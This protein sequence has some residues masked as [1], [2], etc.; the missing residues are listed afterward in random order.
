MT[1]LANGT[2][3][4]SALP[5]LLLSELITRYD[6]GY[7]SVDTSASTLEKWLLLLCK[8]LVFPFYLIVGDLAK[9]DGHIWTRRI[10]ISILIYA[11][12]AATYVILTQLWFSEHTSPLE[13]LVWDIVV[14]LNIV[15]FAVVACA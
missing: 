9:G 10:G 2:T 4:V 6:V 1:A 5:L 14:W 11:V 12:T 15:R 7:F 3:D 8:V 13:A